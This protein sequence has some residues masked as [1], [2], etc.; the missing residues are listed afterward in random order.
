LAA[1]QGDENAGFYGGNWSEV[2]NINFP[3]R[4]SEGERCEPF[5][6]RLRERLEQSSQYFLPCNVLPE[7]P[8][9]IAV[10]NREKFQMIGSLQGK[11]QVFSITIIDSERNTMW[12]LP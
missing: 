1:G 10:L 2:C 6:Q 4:M 9:L 7:P 12:S 11:T 5:R 8:C 3:V